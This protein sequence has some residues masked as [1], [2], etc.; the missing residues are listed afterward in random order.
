[1]GVGGGG[2]GCG[3]SGRGR[4]LRWEGWMGDNGGK[5]RGRNEEG[6]R[7]EMEG[8]REEVGKESGRLFSKAAEMGVLGNW[9]LW[10]HGLNGE[11]DG[12]GRE[13]GWVGK[14]TG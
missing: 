13:T 5:K 3:G 1:M 10:R 8:R 11:T 14:Q 6:R 2:E 12:M 9:N 4:E 7:E